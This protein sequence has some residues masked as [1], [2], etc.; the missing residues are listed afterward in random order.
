MLKGKIPL[1]NMCFSSLQLRFLLRPL[2]VSAML[3]G[4]IRTLKSQDGRE[5]IF[6]SVSVSVETMIRSTDTH[7]FIQKYERV[8]PSQHAGYFMTQ[9][10]TVEIVY[11]PNAP[12]STDTLHH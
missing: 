1:E 7:Y 6:M 2:G 9:T 5:T 8:G 11:G 10:A 3:A 12:F 4:T